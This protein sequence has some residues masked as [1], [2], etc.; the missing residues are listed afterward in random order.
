[1]LP[2]PARRHLFDNRPDRIAG[3]RS[4][5]AFKLAAA[6]GVPQIDP[7][8]GTG[9]I[10]FPVR[11]FICGYRKTTALTTGRSIARAHSITIGLM[12]DFVLRHGAEGQ[13]RFEELLASRFPAIA[14]QI[15]EIAEGLLHLEMAVFARATCSAIDRGD[16]NEVGSTPRVH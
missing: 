16:V 5:T 10:H 1:M 11:A 14:G 13:K 6:N 12:N 2:I 15:S 8:S 7:P 9:A 3:I 4:R